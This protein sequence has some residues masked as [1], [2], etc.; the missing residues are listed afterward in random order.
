MGSNV[1]HIMNGHFRTVHQTRSVKSDDNMTEKK[2]AELFNLLDNLAQRDKES[3]KEFYSKKNIVALKKLAVELNDQM[4]IS[5]EI[6]AS[7]FADCVYELRKIKQTWSRKLGDALIIASD[8]KNRGDL[9]SAKS[10]LE[11][12]IK[13]CPSL[14][15]RN[16]AI[17]QIS[18]YKG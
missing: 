13:D 3:V 9:D 18:N 2:K 14:F 1:L 12:F 10:T 5:D 7:E 6:T 8:N 17:T 15:Y 4:S 16:I 11:N